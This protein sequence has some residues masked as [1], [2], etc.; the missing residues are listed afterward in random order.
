MI[1][2]EISEP[3]KEGIHPSFSQCLPVFI[4]PFGLF[5]LLL[6][7]ARPLYVYIFF[8]WL[9]LFFY[10]LIQWYILSINYVFWPDRVEVRTGLFKGTSRSIPFAEITEI[11][12]KQSIYQKLFKIGDIFIETAGGKDFTLALAGVKYPKQIAQGLFAMKRRGGQ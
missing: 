11:T 2:D 3:E 4:L 6:F 10:K 1:L 12:C 7:G 8:A 5:F 9:E